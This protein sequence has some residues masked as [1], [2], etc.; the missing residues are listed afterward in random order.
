MT[1][2]FQTTL[3]VAFCT[4]FV[5]VC[6]AVIGFFVVRWIKNLDTTL[7]TLAKSVGSFGEIVTAIKGDIMLIHKDLSDHSDDLIELKQRK[8]GHPGCPFYDPAVSMPAR[9]QWTR[10]TDLG[11]SNGG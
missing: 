4:L 7:D 9:T 8:C 3:L 5:A 11:L 2:A 6:G 10:T 1:D